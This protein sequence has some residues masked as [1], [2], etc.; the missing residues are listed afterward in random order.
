MK[1]WLLKPIKVYP[2]L[3]EGGPWTPWYDKAF[4]FVI[5][6]A[7]EKSARNKAAKDCGDEGKQAWLDPQLSSCIELTPKGAAGIVLKDYASA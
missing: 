2:E 3:S 5:R 7:T 6:A 4:G 1:L